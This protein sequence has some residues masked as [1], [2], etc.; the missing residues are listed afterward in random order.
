MATVASTNFFIA[1]PPTFC[2][3][4]PIPALQLPCSGQEKAAA[5]PAPWRDA[6]TTL[7][8]RLATDN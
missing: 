7:T 6:L 5:Q 2:N 1:A 8:M 4:F 3:G